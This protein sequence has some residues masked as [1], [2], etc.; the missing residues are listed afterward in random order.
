MLTGPL[1]LCSVLVLS[2]YALFREVDLEYS[3]MCFFFTWIVFSTAFTL[4]FDCRTFV[5]TVW[6]SILSGVQIFLFGEECNPARGYLPV[7]YL[8]YYSELRSL[9][10]PAR[11]LLLSSPVVLPLPSS[12]LRLV[13][14][15]HLIE[16]GPLFSGPSSFSVP[17]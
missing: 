3:V 11:G 7:Y 10:L 14:Q 15:S 9:H 2:I 6:I 4:L 17:A 1:V 13:S 5:Y 16:R 12:R 8:H